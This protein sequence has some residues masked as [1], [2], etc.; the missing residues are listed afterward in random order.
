MGSCTVPA[1][2]GPP[3]S[4]GLSLPSFFSPCRC[5]WS[6][7]PDVSDADRGTALE[8]TRTQ[9]PPP[10]DVPLCWWMFQF[11][12]Q[13]NRSEE[14]RCSNTTAQLRSS[15]YPGQAM[16][17]SD[18]GSFFCLPVPFGSKSLLLQ[19]PPNVKLNRV[20]ICYGMDLATRFAPGG[21]GQEEIVLSTVR[22]RWSPKQTNSH[23]YIAL[24]GVAI[25]LLSCA[26]RP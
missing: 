16:V 1:V 8:F 20:H 3:I 23:R 13:R 12:K 14:T 10:S 7:N 17:T 6:T 11:M 22:L 4:D 21:L 19:H 25:E 18:A 9:S 5:G 2:P 24:A 15:R 26:D